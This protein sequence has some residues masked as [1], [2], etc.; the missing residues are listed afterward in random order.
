[1]I[2]SLVIAIRTGSH[3]IFI[4]KKIPG[5]ATVTEPTFE[6]CKTGTLTRQTHMGHW[7]A[8]HQ[9]G[10]TGHTLRQR[11]GIVDKEVIVVDTKGA[12][13]GAVLALSTLRATGTAKIESILDCCIVANGAHWI[14]V[15][16]EERVC[17]L[18]ARDT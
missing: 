9:L 16:I 8:I 1:M 4:L 12:V 17:A 2:F 13:E 10:T 11:V 3:T 18:Q 14:A 6:A 15:V 7:G 5:N